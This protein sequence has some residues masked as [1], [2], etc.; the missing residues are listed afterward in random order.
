MSGWPEGNTTRCALLWAHSASCDRPRERYYQSEGRPHARKNGVSD[1]LHAHA[2]HPIPMTIFSFIGEFRSSASSHHLRQIAI[3]LLID[4]MALTQSFGGQSTHRRLIEITC[5]LLRLL[6]N[7]RVFNLSVMRSE[8]TE[9]RRDSVIW[10][11]IWWVIQTLE[12][13]VRFEATMLENGGLSS[14]LGKYRQRFQVV[15]HAPCVEFWVNCRSVMMIR[16]VC[17]SSSSL[18][19]SFFCGWPAIIVCSRS[20][21]NAFD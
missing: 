6:K 20:D 3:R 8:T 13:F 19:S 2:D 18:L 15:R 11:P 4:L 14:V 17:W 10:R 9:L 21:T 5:W 1:P 16:C 7:G 12:A